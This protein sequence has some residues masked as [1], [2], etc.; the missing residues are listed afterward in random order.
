M[1][2]AK[3]KNFLSFWWKLLN[4]LPGDLLQVMVDHIF[5]YR[6]ITAH[7]PMGQPLSQ[8]LIPGNGSQLLNDQTAVHRIEIVFD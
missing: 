7:D 6:V 8:T 5:F 4:G 1:V 2:P 3:L